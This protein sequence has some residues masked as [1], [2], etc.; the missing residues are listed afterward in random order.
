M[1]QLKAWSSV[2]IEIKVAL[3]LRME[4]LGV[5]EHAKSWVTVAQTCNKRVIL[6]ACSWV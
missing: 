5:K 2:D 1:F 4:C 3:A 6:R